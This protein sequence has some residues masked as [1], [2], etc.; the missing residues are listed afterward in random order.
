MLSDVSPRADSFGF[1]RLFRKVVILGDNIVICRVAHSPSA[2]KV[3]VAG[4]CNTAPVVLSEI[5][6]IASPPEVISAR[7]HC[8]WL[9]HESNNRHFSRSQLDALEGAAGALVELIVDDE[10]G[11]S[12][13][14]DRERRKS[15][16]KKN[17]AH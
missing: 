5:V 10:R 6:C 8:I 1:V 2:Q 9:S 16:S 17:A 12:D 7:P 11:D 13:Q 14:G 3:L 4:F 15:D